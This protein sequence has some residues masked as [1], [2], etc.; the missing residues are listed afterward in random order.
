MKRFLAVFFARNLEFFRDRSTFFWNLFFPIFLIFGFAF[1][2]SGNNPVSYKIGLIGKSSTNLEFLQYKYLQFIPYESLDISVKKLLHHQIDMVL[3][4]KKDNYYINTEDSSGYL[5]ERILLSDPSQHLQKK[6]VTGQKIRY[7]DW[8]VPGVLGMNIML[9]CLMGV[10]FVI[11]RYR[12]NGV[13]KRFKATPL[14]AIEFISAQL[15]SRFFIVAFMST[16]IYFGTNI[17][18][19]FKME[20]SYL[21]LILITFIAI[22]CHISLGL[23]FSTRIKSEEF[24]GGLINLI[25][26]PMMILS[27]IF[28]SLEG[29]PPIM[30]QVSKI[31]PI[32]HFIDAARKIMLDGTPL[33]GVVDNLIVLVLLTIVFLIISAVLFKWE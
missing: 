29:T 3:D 11:I 20:G 13:L 2:F 10:G 21:D 15:F 12:K 7:V 19:K 22:F 16:L 31:F 26:W 9:G 28:F 30:Q 18:L 32:T 23:L 4:L 24:G 25:M 8:F 17:F 5:I 6:T 14:H 1:A 33:I 27:G